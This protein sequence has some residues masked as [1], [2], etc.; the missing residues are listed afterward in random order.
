M[1]NW[2]R[3]MV[4]AI[5]A[6]AI[7]WATC[8][9]AEERVRETRTI[10]PPFSEVRL[11]GALD[12]QLTQSDAASLVIEA[13]RG[14]LSHVKSEV[15]EGVLT[16]R[17]DDD[18][19]RRRLGFFARH[20]APRALLSAKAIDR[21]AVEGS[22]DVGAGAWTF[23]SAFELRVAGSGDVK[24]DHLAAEQLTCSIAGSGNIELAGSTT[25]QDVR[26]S[27]SGSYH[28]AHLKSQ[29]ASVSVVGSGDAELWAERVLE[30]RIAGSGEVRYYGS[31]ALKQSV[32]GSGSLTALG[33]NR[34]R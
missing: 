15:H 2:N 24:F 7:A 4:H 23:P 17:L 20:S 34:S 21:L 32:L 3:W 31:P 25:G 6:S 27:G 13:D 29:T 9:A 18:G 26:I 8:A 1:Q 14:E 5:G 19:A 10:A 28:A 11:I 30:V 22:G 33:V 16:L 12:L